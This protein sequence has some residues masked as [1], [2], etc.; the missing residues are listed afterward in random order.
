MPSTE[1]V[2]TGPKHI[3]FHN[4][5][6][7]QI[8]H[9]GIIKG[10]PPHHLQLGSTIEKER[11]NGTMVQEIIPY[12]LGTIK[13]TDLR[14]AYGHDFLLHNPH[15]ETEKVSYLVRTA[16]MFGADG[17]ATYNVA[18]C[19]IPSPHKFENKKTWVT[20]TVNNTINPYLSQMGFE[21]EK[22][23]FPTILISMHDQSLTVSYKG[24]LDEFLGEI[25][26]S[27]P[28]ESE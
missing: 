11:E 15:D 28:D 3:D 21:S 18:V 12:V 25:Y 13:Q 22:T 5:I 20:E 7:T 10:F 9:L 23:E 24:E 4:F 14:A 2:E 6:V 16:R 26:S 17:E 19:R 27:F 8:L 1:R